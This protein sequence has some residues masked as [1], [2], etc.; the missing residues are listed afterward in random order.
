MLAAAEALPD[1]PKH[2]E[3]LWNA[4]Q[5]FQNAHLVGQALKARLQLIEA[6]P[7]DPLAQKALF[8]VAAGYHQLAYYS[9][10]AEH[11]EDFAN[12]F[13][14]EKKATDALGNATTFRIGLGESDKAIADM[15]SF[16]KFYGTRKPQDAAGVFFQMGD[17]YEKEKKY[18]ELAKHLENYLKKWGAAGRSGPP[19]AGALPPR[20]AG[21]EGL[22]PEGG[23]GRRLPRD[24]ARRRHRPPE[25][26][27]RPQ[28]EAE[29]GQEDPRGE[30]DAVRPAHQLEDRP[31]RPQQAARRPRRQEHFLAVLKIW[32]KGAAASK[33][34]GKDVEAPRGPG[35]L[36]RRR[37]GLLHGRGP[38]REL[39][40]HQ[41]PRGPRLPAAEPVRQQEEGRGQEEEGRGVG[42]KF[43]SYLD[44]KSKAL[45]KARDQYLDVFE[46]KQ[47]Q[48]TIASSARIGQLYADFVGQLYTAEI[49]KDL[50]EQDEWGN[51]PREI[52]CDALV[53]KAEPIEAKAVEGFE[54]CLKAATDY[55]WYNEWSRLCERELNQMKPTEYPLSSEV[56]PEAGYVSTTMSPTTVVPELSRVRSAARPLL[57]SRVTSEDGSDERPADEEQHAAAGSRSGLLVAFAVSPLAAS[58]RAA[59]AAAPS[60]SRRPP[61]PN[62]ERR[63]HGRRRRRSTAPSARPAPSSSS[64]RRRSAHIS[65]DAARRLRQG[66]AA[67]RGRPRSRAAS[68][69]RSARSVSDA[70]KRVADDNPGLLEARFNQGAVLAECGRED[71][72]AR[73]WEGLQVRPG[74]QPTSATSPGSTATRRGPSRCSPAP[75]QV[76]PLHTVEARNNLAQILRDK[77]R[78]RLERRREEA[79]RRP[80]GQQPA[81]RAGARQQ[82]PAGVLDAGV[83]LLRHEHAGDG[84][85]GRQPG[86][87][88]GGR[89]R[90]RQVRGGEGRGGRRG[91][92]RQGARRARRRRRK[93]GDDDEGGKLAKEVNVREAGTGVTDDMK[94]QLAVV[95][96]TLGLVELKKKNISPAI[97][98]QE[99]GR[100]E[101]ELR[102]GAPQPGGA[103]AQQPR[104]QHRRGELPRGARA[105]AEELRG[106][107]RP[108]RRAARQQED[109]RGGDAVQRR[110]EARSVEPVQLLQPRPA[111]P[112][113]QGRPEAG[114]AQGAGLL[115]AVPGP[116]QRLDARLLKRE[117]EKRIKDIDEI[118]VALD[119]AAKM[120]AE[121]EEMQKKAEEQ[122]KQMEEQ[123]KKQEADEGRCCQGARPSKAAPKGG[124]GTAPPTR[125]PPAP[126]RR[127]GDADKAAAG[128]APADDQ[129]GGDKDE[130]APA[131]KKGKKK[132]SSSAVASGRT[133]RATP[134]RTVVE[135]VDSLE[136]RELAVV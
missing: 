131:G 128:A 108:R 121:A 84:Q 65:D 81:H 15:D 49:P 55:S 112:G 54:K 21:L 72:A 22:L 90:D 64:P 75:S 102:R 39:P 20:R 43:G 95:Y 113:L 88:E 69:A 61:A 71:D 41:V 14:G 51:R 87:Q 27:L 106:R 116:R 66:D 98:I 56:K 4:G 127:R 59:P 85:A 117:A 29:E 99:G 114:A 24:Q 57:P 5:C 82:Q 110:P 13:P 25:G 2:A 60:R 83:H 125:P 76:D 18:D 48:W 107:H 38:V 42:K 111:L 31:L 3:R 86:H 126:A 103:V 133:R 9:K 33:I 109:R 45:D 30:A 34:T 104:L 79:V 70:F 77:A 132:K 67:L 40:P 35:G 89:D 17:V 63:H 119:E 93:A 100:D 10:A 122:Q 16:V 8:R 129:G 120:Q 130:A 115:P 73:I 7:K 118:Y 37:R 58:R 94:K 97:Q 32:N 62:R 23:R 46:M 52:F 101:P 6:H 80:G 78:Q 19:G 135:K 134:Q 53:D 96:N 28:Q 26:P 124:A 91:Q 92:G 136:P 74:D 12:K 11:Y 1:H 105:A 36:R 123:M 68:P 47:A 50:K 44:E